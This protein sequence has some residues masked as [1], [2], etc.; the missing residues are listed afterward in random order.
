MDLL[1]LAPDIQAEILHLEVEPGAQ[2]LAERAL[3]KLLRSP[4]WEE[5]RREWAK[6]AGSAGLVSPLGAAPHPR[7]AVGGR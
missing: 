6:V 2:P 5:Q 7:V 4:V 1:L 3:R